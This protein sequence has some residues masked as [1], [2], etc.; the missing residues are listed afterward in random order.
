MLFDMVAD[1]SQSD[2]APDAQ[3][4]EFGM[5]VQVPGRVFP[6][7]DDSPRDWHRASELIRNGCSFDY[8]DLDSGAGTFRWLLEYGIVRKE[9]MAEKILN[10]LDQSTIIGRVSISHNMKCKEFLS[11]FSFRNLASCA[12]RLNF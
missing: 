11:F 9:P 12:R 7:D 6:D 3:C 10:Q 5:Y 8:V 2:W 4:A 1:N